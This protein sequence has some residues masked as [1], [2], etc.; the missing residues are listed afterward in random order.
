[1]LQR[2]RLAMQSGTFDKMGGGGPIEADET[3]IGGKARNMHKHKRAEKIKG[4]GGK[5]KELVMGLLDREIAEG[6][7]RPCAK[8]AEGD[9]AAPMKDE[10]RDGRRAVH[11]RAG[12]ATPASKPTTSTRSSTTPRSTSTAT[13]TRTASRTSGVLL[14]RTLKGTYVSV[15]P[16]HL[17]RY[18]DEQAFRFNERKHE[19]GDAGRFDGCAPGRSSAGASRTRT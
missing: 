17:F 4:T 9:A 18:L 8:P 10:R 7:R 3:F 15:E 6:P 12:V 5:G 13:S 1:M 19:D 11:R 16:F 2:I 14:K